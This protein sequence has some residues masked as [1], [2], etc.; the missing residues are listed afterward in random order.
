MNGSKLPENSSD[1][2]NKLVKNEWYI[3]LLQYERTRNPH[4]DLHFSSFSCER[5]SSRLQ[6]QAKMKRISPTFDQRINK[7]G[8]VQI[9]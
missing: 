9:Q 6:H 8:R 3:P 7:D 1:H 5:V 2:K 4:V